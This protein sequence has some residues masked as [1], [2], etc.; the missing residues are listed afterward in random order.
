MN[1]LKFN[2]TFSDPPIARFLFSD[3]RAAWLWLPCGFGWAGIG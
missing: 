1:I 2:T 3:K